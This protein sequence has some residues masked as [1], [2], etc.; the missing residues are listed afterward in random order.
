MGEAANKEKAEFNPP[1]WF[2]KLMSRSHDTL[3]R[4]TFG[5]AFNT[6][7]G[8]EVVFVTMTGAKTGKRITIPL[9]HVPYEDGVLLVASLGGAPRHPAWYH[10]VK[11]NPD[12]RVRYRGETR[13]MRARLAT[14]EE[15]PALWPVCDAHYAPYATYRARTDRDIPIFICSPRASG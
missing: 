9:M 12:I 3:N 11:A 14:A 13:E 7:S 1:K 5:K 8:D 10:S 6:L 4:L 15:K 2:M